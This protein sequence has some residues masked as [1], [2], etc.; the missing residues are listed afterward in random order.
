MRKI[1][2]FAFALVAGVVAFTSC[3]K[4]NGN[5]LIGKWSFDTEKTQ[6]GY[7]ETQSVI[8]EENGNFIFQ[9]VQHP[10]DPQAFNFVMVMEGTYKVHGE[11]ITVHFTKHGWDHG[12][13]MEYIPG[14]EPYDDEMKYAISGKQLTL[15]RN[16][17]EDYASEETYTKQ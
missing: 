7:Y 5:A 9:A 8:F 10:E 3:E 15:T 2:F 11:F 4:K 13:G 14:W 12:D 1:L 17:G 16:Y 6:G